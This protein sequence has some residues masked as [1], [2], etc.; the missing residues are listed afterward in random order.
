MIPA[1]LLCAYD[2]RLA[3]MGGIGV[4]VSGTGMLSYVNPAAVFFDDNQYTF[5][6]SASLADVVGLDPWP[7]N[8]ASSLEALFTASLVTAGID[9]SYNAVNRRDDAHVDVVQDVRL[10]VDISAGYGI[11]SA[12][13]GVTGGSRMQR[14]DVPMAELSD[15]AVQTLFAPFDRVV[16]SEYIQLRAGVML[17]LGQFYI[18]ML[19]DDLL[20]KKD[21][22]MVFEWDAIFKGSG[23]GV[24]WSSPEF[25]ARGRMNNLVFSAGAE[26]RNIFKP[27]E[28][29]LCSGAEV[30]FRFTRTSGVSLRA[31]YTSL[32]RNLG[33][34][35]VT[36]GAGADL[37]HLTVSLNA[38]FPIGGNP[39]VR[40]TVIA[41]I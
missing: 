1:A 28:R 15:F 12:G 7:C 10:D 31:G 3:A 24:Y 14:L 23:T 8:P 9:I 6:L 21:S 16:N 38:E 17:S 5:A 35:T 20:Q 13:V 32:L 25:S 41:L 2:P 30:R 34:G 27:E 36:A 40:A 37:T 4:G 19:M 22:G 33:G 39:V 11:V 18:G 29:R 26:V